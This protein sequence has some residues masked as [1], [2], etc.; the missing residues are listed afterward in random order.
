MNNYVGYL[1]TSTKKQLL[2]I[3]AQQ[4]KIKDFI[5]KEMDLFC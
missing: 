5:S 3:A 4:D 2:G 1:R